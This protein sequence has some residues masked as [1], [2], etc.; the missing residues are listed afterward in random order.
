MHGQQNIKSGNWLPVDT[1][2]LQYTRIFNNTVETVSDPPQRNRNFLIARITVK[3]WMNQSLYCTN[4]DTFCAELPCSSRAMPIAAV[5]TSSTLRFAPRTERLLSSRLATRAAGNSSTT[6]EPWWAKGAFTRV[7]QAD[8]RGWRVNKL[9]MANF[10]STSLIHF[11]W[12][13]TD[14]PCKQASHDLFPSVER[15]LL[16]C[17]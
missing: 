7:P 17:V 13:T 2:T 15:V 1:V 6:T 5:T 3:C 8:Q 10:R 16:V 11:G 9:A 14:Y 12:L 4:V